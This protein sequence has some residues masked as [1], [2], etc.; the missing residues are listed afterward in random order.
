MQNKKENEG[1][2]EIFNDF[3]KK[4]S[5]K[6]IIFEKQEQFYFIINISCFFRQGI[7]SFPSLEQWPNLDFN[8]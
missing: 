3:V 7:L 2:C 5:V 1:G 4:S 6:E 8:V